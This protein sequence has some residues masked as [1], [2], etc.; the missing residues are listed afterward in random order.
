MGA[1][2]LRTSA[3][4]TRAK[5]SESAADTSVIADVGSGALG[6]DVFNVFWRRA[7]SSA[8]SDCILDNVEADSWK[9]W[10]KLSRSFRD[11]FILSEM[12]ESWLEIASWADS[13]C[14][15]AAELW[16]WSSEWRSSI[17]LRVRRSCCLEYESANIPNT[18][19]AFLYASKRN[20][21]GL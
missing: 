13:C 16:L 21:L 14:W 15:R 6:A 5:I 3:R 4:K 8:V 18:S 9:A 11:C 12:V 1:R 20:F 10:R 17:C 7:M 19:S 2:T